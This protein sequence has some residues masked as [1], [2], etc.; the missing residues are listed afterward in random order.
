M[1]PAWAGTVQRAFTL[2]TRGNRRERG[3]D[4][5][6]HAAKQGAE[7]GRLRQTHPSVNA[8]TLAG[9]ATA[10]LAVHGFDRTGRQMPPSKPFAPRVS[11]PRASARPQASPKVKPAAVTVTRNL[12]DDAWLAVFMQ[13]THDDNNRR[14]KATL[15]LNAG[16]L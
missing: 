13:A 9:L 15:R 5:A 12:A 10:M 8:A 3:I 4:R 2:P 16:A 1:S 6:A 11:K 7:I 14:R